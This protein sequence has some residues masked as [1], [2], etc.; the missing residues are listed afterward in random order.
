MFDKNNHVVWSARHSLYGEAEVFDA[1]IDNNIRFPG[2]YFDSES[3]LHYNYYRY[4]DPYLGRYIESDPI[5]F[6]GGVNTYAYVGSNP[7]AFFDPYG[8]HK[9]DQWFG[10]DDKNF[11]DWAHQKKQE[12]DLPGNSNYTKKNIED[13]WKQ[14]HDEGKP[15]GKG[16]KSGKGGKGR[17]GSLVPIFGCTTTFDCFCLDYPEH[18]PGFWNPNGQNDQNVYCPDAQGEDNTPNN[19]NCTFEEW[20]SNLCS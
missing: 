4:Y 11:R 9:K 17:A 7:I 16:G 5:G 2:Q 1:E 14:W 18:C 3:G 13:L 20:K 15:R 6:A 12:L 8:L 19:P 10:G